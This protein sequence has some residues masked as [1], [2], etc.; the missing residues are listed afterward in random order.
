MF[1]IDFHFFWT[2][3]FACYSDAFDAFNWISVFFSLLLLEQYRVTNFRRKKNKNVFSMF[4]RVRIHGRLTKNH[5]WFRFSRHIPPA[6]KQFS[7]RDLYLMP[8]PSERE[9]RQE[10]QNFHFFWKCWFF[11]D[12]SG[13]K[14]TEQTIFN[15]MIFIDFDSL[16]L[17][18]WKIHR[19]DL[20]QEI[21]HN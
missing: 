21:K 20:I 11:F 10:T 1:F 5:E 18:I 14:H 6:S 9:N 12:H 15:F 2:L 8:V 13:R 4:S 17:E 3:Y 16:I 7:K 19:P